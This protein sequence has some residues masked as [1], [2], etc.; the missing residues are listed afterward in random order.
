MYE[1]PKTV[2]LKCFDITVNVNLSLQEVQKN[3]W[4][5]IRDTRYY[6]FISEINTE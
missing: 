4:E 2:P 1:E 3:Y 6:T 5:Y